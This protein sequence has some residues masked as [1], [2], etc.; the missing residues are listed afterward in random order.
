MGLLQLQGVQ[1]GHGYIKKFAVIDIMLRKLQ[2]QTE[3][4]PEQ[5]RRIDTDVSY[6]REN[7]GKGLEVPVFY[8]SLLEI[9][10]S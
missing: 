10:F 3:E 4:L 7:P 8:G 6:G 9:N 1:D 5:F 2:K